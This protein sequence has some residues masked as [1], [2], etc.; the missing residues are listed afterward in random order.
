M[1]NFNANLATANLTL[2][3]YVAYVPFV[4]LDNTDEQEILT[5]DLPRFTDG[6]GLR[7]IAVSQGAGTGN[8]NL[9]MTY[10]N[11]IRSSRI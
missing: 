7:V 5:I 3:D 4:D 8:T 11:M 1:M 2:M 10:I 9:T 6:K